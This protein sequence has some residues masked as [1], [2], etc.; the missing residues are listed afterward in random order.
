MKEIVLSESV[1]W[2]LETI[3]EKLEWLYRETAEKLHFTCHG[4]SDN[5][6]DS[7]FQH[8]TYL[9]WAYLDLGLKTFPEEKRKTIR[10]R[11]L[12]YQERCKLA[13][14]R[15]ERP[16]VMCPLNEDGLCI[17]YRYRLLVCRTHGVP[18]TMTRP[19][20][21]QLAFP[22]CFRCQEKIQKRFIHQSQAPHVERTPLLQQLA[23]LENELLDNKRH[24]YPRVKMTI[25]DMILAGPP[26]INGCGR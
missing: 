5:C 24:V 7:Y 23:R 16:Q 18:A 8:H 25:A 22:G 9:E 3:Y 4:C 11:A 10:N 12:D 14:K 26:T 20:G 13:E 21:R 2:Q 19:D 15:G 6:C 1:I 17:I